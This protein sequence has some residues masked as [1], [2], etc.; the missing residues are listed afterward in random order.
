MSRSSVIIIIVLAS[1]AVVLASFGVKT[2]F[3][4]L[5]GKQNMATSSAQPSNKKVAAAVGNPLP[6]RLVN[7]AVR[8]AA[9]QYVLEG[10]LKEVKN[11]PQGSEL[12]T[13]IMGQEK[14]KFI[15]TNKTTVVFNN[16]GQ[17]TPANTSDLKPG[18]KLRITATFGLKRRVWTTQRVAILT[19]GSSVS[20]PSASPK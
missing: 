4:S 15:V 7:P 8:S 10:N 3:P 9:V 17:V 12:V 13:T 2:F 11:T 19:G 1:V 16:K 18:Q 14:P 5:T 6:I 20:T